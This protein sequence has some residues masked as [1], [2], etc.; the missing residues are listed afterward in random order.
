MQAL[1][2]HIFSSTCQGRPVRV[3][4]AWDRQMEGF[5]MVVELA[6]QGERLYASGTDPGLDDLGGLA[7]SLD[8]LTGKLD[9]MGIARP[10]ALDAEI[11]ADWLADRGGRTVRYDAH[12]R[13]HRIA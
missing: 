11:E 2:C 1:S 8:Y 7:A 10:A 9:A 12:G 5:R 4:M 6:G 3:E 13:P